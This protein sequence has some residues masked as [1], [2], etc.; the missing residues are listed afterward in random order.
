MRNTIITSVS[1]LA[2]LV[3]GLFIGKSNKRIEIQTIVKTNIVEK[4]VIE[5]VDKYITNVIEKV[6]EAEIPE[7]YKNALDIH[8]RLLNANYIKSQLTIYENQLE[9]LRSLLEQNDLLA[10]ERKDDP[11]LLKEIKRDQNDIYAE[12]R[13]I[14]KELNKLIKEKKW[15]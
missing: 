1:A 9:K 6:V 11:S 7:N 15:K 2:F 3:I 10:L 4:P 8:K 12:I 14:E 13:N 5:Y